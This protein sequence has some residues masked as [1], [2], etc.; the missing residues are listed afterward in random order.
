MLSEAYRIH[1]TK[2]L[3]VTAVGIG[4]SVTTHR[5]QFGNNIA[6]LHVRQLWRQI[7]SR[8]N[9]V[10]AVKPRLGMPM[11]SAAMAVARAEMVQQRGVK[12]LRRGCSARPLVVS[13]QRRR[14]DS[15]LPHMS[16]KRKTSPCNLCSGRCSFEYCLNKA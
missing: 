15:R 3:N 2:V 14:V 1:S 5:C 16:M 9:S 6:T 4:D 12:F 10:L 11:Q 7:K 8:V 13:V